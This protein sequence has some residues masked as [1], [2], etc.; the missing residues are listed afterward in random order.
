MAK[1]ALLDVVPDSRRKVIYWEED[2]K[3]FVETKQDVSH[4]VQ[5]AKILSEEKPG[6]DFRRVGFIPDTVLNE[7]M[8]EGWFHDPEAWRRWAN[9]PEN[10]CY[11]TWH[12]RL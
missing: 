12:G 4:I 8:T 7:A 9:A 2:G 10:A 11:R 5:A 1:G 6:K 3:T